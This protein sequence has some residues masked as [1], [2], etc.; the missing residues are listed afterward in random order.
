M[1]KREKVT[2]S[3][4]FIYKVFLDIYRQCPTARF[5]SEKVKKILD[6]IAK[7]VP[8]KEAKK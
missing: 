8:E 5:T 7:Y 2:F 4:M 1:S 6:E 3:P